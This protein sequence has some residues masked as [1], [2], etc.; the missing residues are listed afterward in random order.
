MI[1]QT[2]LTFLNHVFTIGRQ[3]TEAIRLHMD[4]S[5]KEAEARASG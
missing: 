4:V 3:I 2:P 1:C 5:K